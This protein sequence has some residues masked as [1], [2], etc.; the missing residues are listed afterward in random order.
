MVRLRRWWDN[1]PILNKV[2][3]GNA[4]VVLVGALGGTLLTDLLVNVSGMFLALFYSAFGIL[5][6]LIINYHILNSALRPMDA[7][8]ETVEKIDSGDTGVRA[9][10]EDIGDPQL[11]AFAQALN[12]MLGRLAAHTQII[13]TSRAQLRRLSGQVLSA[14]E[15]ERKRLARE[16]HDDT[17]GALAR[18]I[19]NLEMCEESLPDDLTET[20]TRVRGTRVLAE[21]TLE[22]TRK[23]IFDL[24]PT[25]LDDLGLAAAV[26]W[27]AKTNLEPAG[28][29]VQFE[30]SSTLGRASAPIETA[31]FR[32]AQEAINNIIR[33]ASAH[34]AQIQLTREGTHWILRIRDDGCGFDVT[35]LSH[36]PDIKLDHHW[37]LFG[38][39]ER[40]NLLGGR[41]E[42]RSSPGKG[43]TLR[44]EIPVE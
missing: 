26:R 34:H 28:I 4:L 42:V 19:L 9:P 31:M 1:T 3:I 12:T 35:A 17:S 5:F 37:G 8:Q 11:K 15:E 30:A 23:M 10:V 44:V 32:I 24:R 18:V 36:L 21:Q 7:L 39:D 22:N 2:L 27:Y 6:S 43:T 13:E 20:R 29:N 38:M 41:L 40:A 14:Q 16:L 25:L 33:H